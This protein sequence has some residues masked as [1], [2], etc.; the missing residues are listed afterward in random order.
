[1]SRPSSPVHF[2]RRGTALLVGYG[3]I[4]LGAAALF[5]AY[6]ARGKGKPFWVKLLP[7]A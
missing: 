7:G 6:E 4:I 1:M 5:D 2:R 3:G